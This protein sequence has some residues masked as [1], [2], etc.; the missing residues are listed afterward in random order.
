MAELS[1]KTNPSVNAN[2]V[3]YLCAAPKGTNYLGVTRSDSVTIS[4]S[5]PQAYFGIWY[6][7]ADKFN[8]L[9]FYRGTTLL[10]SVTGTG[11]VLSVLP[12]SYNGNPTAAF[13]GQDSN[14]KFVFIDFSAQTTDDMFDKIV[15]SNGGG[16]TIFESDNHTF[17]AAI[18][19]PPPGMS[20]VPEPNTFA[21][22]GVGGL[23]VA[24]HELFRRCRRKSSS[25]QCSLEC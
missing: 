4:L 11:P 24:I 22:I 13:H 7:A 17:S 19:N 20:A 3:T 21:L 9:S 12:S 5:T 15:L 6:S 1:A 16:T 23:G 14:E 10:A 2:S 18:Q 8:D 25:S